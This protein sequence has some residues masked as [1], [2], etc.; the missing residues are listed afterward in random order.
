[1][2]VKPRWVFV[3]ARV[4][5]ICVVICPRVYSLVCDTMVASAEDILCEFNVYL[6]VM[7][8]EF[9]N[10]IST[11]FILSSSLLL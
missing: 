6:V 2:T 5:I 1:M 10:P 4:W 8:F 7:S 3:Y 9:V 11:K